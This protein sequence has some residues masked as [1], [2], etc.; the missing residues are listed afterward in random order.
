MEDAG[1]NLRHTGGARRVDQ[2][3]V[4]LFQLRFH[5]LGRG[6][7][8]AQAE[9]ADD[10]TVLVAQRHFAR[11]H[12][13]LAAVRPD[14]ALKF[15]EYGR[16]RAHDV[17]LI[18]AGPLGVLGGK[19]IGVGFAD[20]FVGFEF[21]AAHLGAADGDELAFPILEVDEVGDVFEKRRH[22]C[23][24]EERGGRLMNVV[25]GKRCQVHSEG[26]AGGAAGRS[27]VKAAPRPGPSLEAI[28]VPFISR[29]AFALEWSP[30]P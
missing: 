26:R 18:D 20:H 25:G 17:L 5:V 14:N 7:I 8:F 27:S 15:A 29:A 24:I 19:E 22:E 30:K 9:G 16:A 13:G 23:A 10:F 6:H 11:E 2:I 12:P 3:F 21:V 28:S 4:R 1:C